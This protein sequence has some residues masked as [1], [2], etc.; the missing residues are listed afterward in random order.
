MESIRG[1]ALS[2]RVVHMCAWVGGA[3]VSTQSNFL[4][5][6]SLPY[7]NQ[8]PS[9]SPSHSAFSSTMS[10]VIRRKLSPPPE[11]ASLEFYNRN[12]KR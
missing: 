12:K 6:L 2:G 3:N 5:I 9:E 1:G 4:L 7:N 11:D 8:Y 10:H